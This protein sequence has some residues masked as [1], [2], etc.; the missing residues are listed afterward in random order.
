M[1][2]IVVLG[3][4]MVDVVVHLEGRLVH[5]SDTPARIRFRG[6]GSAAN[7]ATWLAA[8]GAAPV[9]VGR[10][11]ADDAGRDAA[12][13]LQEAG[14]DARLARDP[15]LPTGI[16]IVLVG[17]DGERTMIPDAGA[18]DGLSEGD[19]PAELLARGDHLH[20][21]GYSLLRA[22]SRAAAASAI[23]AAAALGMTVSVDPS[24]AALLEP[25]FLT[26]ALGATLLL[27]NALE[28][29]ALTGEPDV[30]AAARALSRR[31][32]EV[33]VKLGA[34]GAL[35]TNGSDELTAPAEAVETVVDLTGAGDAFSAGLLAA[36]LAGAG[37]REA[38]GAG[39]RLA[40]R[41]VVTPGGRPA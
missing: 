19:L 18:N 15:E 33:V 40:G 9:F 24:S 8:A 36:R 6:G 30:R 39:C 41:A 34:D 25:D 11:G 3:D 31:F 23:R 13:E 22:G 4:V 7:T 38:L 17:V 35:W 32:A 5:A 14:V 12:R 26:A 27:P 16:C 28:A 20:V 37:P 10:V 29:R 21:A 1:S 2:R